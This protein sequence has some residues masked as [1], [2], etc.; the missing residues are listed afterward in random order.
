MI[1]KLHTSPLK[2]SDSF[3]LLDISS[4]G[5]YASVPILVGFAHCLSRETILLHPKSPILIV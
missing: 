5:K 1:P 4:G 2:R 3:C